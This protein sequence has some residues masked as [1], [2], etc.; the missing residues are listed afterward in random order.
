T[1]PVI[2]LV[3]EGEIIA[4]SMKLF[5]EPGFSAEDVVDGDLTDSVT[6]EYVEDGEV[7]VV[8]YSVS[9][10]AGNSTTEQRR[11][12]VKD[13]VAPEITLNGDAKEKTD[14]AKWRDPG[15]EAIDDLDGDI[16]ESV[17]VETDYVEATEGTFNFLY[18]AKDKAG[19]TSSVTRKLTVKDGEPPVI[20]LVGGPALYINKGDAFDDPG[21]TAKDGFEGKVKVKMKG[22][23]DTSSVGK[24][25]VTYSASDSKGNTA[26][27]ERTVFV[28]ESPVQNADGIT[29]G[30]VVSDSTIYLTFDDGPSYITPKILDILAKYNVKATFFILNY[31]DENREVIA[32]AIREGH[33]IGIHGYSHDYGIIYTSAEAGIE[34]ITKLYDRL[35]NDFGY[36]TNITRFPGG[37][38]NTISR[39]YRIGVMSELCPLA[40]QLGYTYFDW[41]VSSED[42]T[43][44][45]IPASTIYSSVVN[46][47]RHDRSNVVLMHD[48]YGKDT[49]AEAL[50]Q[51]IEYG[52][53]NDYTFAALS[54]NTPPVHHP[55]NN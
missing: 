50:S 42:A 40:E 44:G 46:N 17:T 48:S 47:L 15:V 23:V 28:S 22:D 37:S 9:D 32:R 52:M 13:I 39:N 34:N 25:T 20:S 51:I 5:V 3:D 26:T 21:A 18:V 2:T 38:S 27:L 10:K 4:S 14:K 55:I 6:F 41:N 19:N 36:S 1:P 24:Y 43:G 16:S 29:G 54:S 49:T 8:I 53:A 30:G 7:G 12:T 33:T 11:V 35:V 31:S 45:G